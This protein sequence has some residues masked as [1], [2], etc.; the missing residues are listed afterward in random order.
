MLERVAWAVCSRLKSIHARL[1]V[2]FKLC[3]DCHEYMKAASKLLVRPIVV[4]EPKRH[5]TFADGRCSC[6]DQWSWDAQLESG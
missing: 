2:N 6:R 3:L 1:S 5:H 4:C